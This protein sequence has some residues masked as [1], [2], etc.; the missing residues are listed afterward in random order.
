M[1]LIVALN[2]DNIIGNNNDIPWTLKN[3]LQR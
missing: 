1:H 2:Q 3:D